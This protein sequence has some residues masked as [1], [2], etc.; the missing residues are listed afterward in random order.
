MRH[1]YHSAKIALGMMGLRKAFTGPLWIQIGIANP[2]NHRCIMCWDHPSFPRQ[3][4][5]DTAQQRQTISQEP[6]EFTNPGNQFMELNMLKDLMEDLQHLG[7][8]RIELAGR[9]EPTLHPKF[10]Q[11]VEMLKKHSFN[12]GIVT[13][14]SLLSRQ[15]YEHL[16]SNGVD[17]VVISLNAATSDTYPRIHTTAKPE[18]FDQIIHNLHE[19]R[20]IKQSQGKKK[21]RVMLSF[22]ISCANFQQGFQMIER[23]KEVGA[24]QVVFK[25]AIPH[26]NVAFIELTAKEKNEFSGHLPAFVERAESYG[27]N[28]KVEPPIGDMTGEAYI[29]HK[30]TKVIYSKIPCYIGWVFSLITAE[31]LVMPCCQCNETMGDLRNQRFREIWHSK[32]YDNFRARMKGF[33]KLRPVPLN[34]GCDEC[35]FE[36][37]NTTIYNI[38]HFYHPVT[39]HRAQRDFSLLQL[40]PAIFK[41]KTTRGAKDRKEHFERRDH[42]C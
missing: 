11:I 28:L 29:Y 39:L 9:G 1:F 4:R 21:P 22:V 36:K 31:G 3:N 25:Y 14:G 18:T 2:C 24:D 20:Q 10:A 15:Q 16:V 27:I 34:C 40:L 13:N 7:T 32:K 19:L 35:S 33:P 26:P 42:I 38:L 23:G 5:V 12:V 17:R 6:N 41:G 30:K 8:R 37:I